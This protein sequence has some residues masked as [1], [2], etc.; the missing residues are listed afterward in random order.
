MS[1][2]ESKASAAGLSKSEWI[3]RI[4]MVPQM[5]GT[6]STLTQGE[7]LGQQILAALDEMLEQLRMSN[8]STAQIDNDLDVPGFLKHIKPY[9][10]DEE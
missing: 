9:V 4:V 10:D 3:R 7:E 2:L 1:V 5:Y 8:P 6:T